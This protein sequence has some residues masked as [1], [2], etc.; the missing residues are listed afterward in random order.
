MNLRIVG[1]GHA[2]EAHDEMMR[3]AHEEVP[4]G[5]AAVQQ[6]QTVIS[7]SKMS[8]VERKSTRAIREPQVDDDAVD[9]KPARED[10]DVD[11]VASRI[12]L[13]DPAARRHVYGRHSIVSKTLTAATTSTI[14]D[15]VT[16]FQNS[17]P[18]D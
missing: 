18:T 7:A 15:T 5:R 2:V 4:D 16:Q 8:S 9:Q 13:N 10:C 17:R 14:T 3:S 6:P 1:P 12:F 11:V